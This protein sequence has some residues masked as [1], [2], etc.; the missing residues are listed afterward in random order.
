MKKEIKIVRNTIKYLKL[1][2]HDKY[3]IVQNLEMISTILNSTT[4]YIKSSTV[5]ERLYGWTSPC[6]AGQ[7]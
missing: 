3:G 4:L 2:T 7:Q 5:P 1:K 6:H